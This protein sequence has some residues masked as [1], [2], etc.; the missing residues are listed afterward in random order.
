MRSGHVVAV[1][2]FELVM[3]RNIKDSFINSGLGPIDYRF[4][5]EFEHGHNFSEQKK[6]NYH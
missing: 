2:G 5:H 1:Y 4:M 3:E 6:S